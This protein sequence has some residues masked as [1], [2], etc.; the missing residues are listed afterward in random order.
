M[1]NLLDR[2]FALALPPGLSASSP[3]AREQMR[4]SRFT[5]GSLLLMICAFL[6][7]APIMILFSPHTPAAPPIAFGVLGLL[8]FTLIMSRLGRQKFAACCLIAFIFILVTGP[9]LSN[10]L[11]FSLLP[12]FSVFIV[13]TILAGVLLP[14][15][16]AIITG[17]ISCAMIAVIG[18]MSLHPGNYPRAAGR[19]SY[20]FINVISLAIMTPMIINIVIAIIVY[21]IMRSLLLTIRRA[22]QAEEIVA[23][24]SAIAAHERERMQEQRQLEE[25]LEKIAEAHARI[26]NGD[27]QARVS[28]RDG[29]VLWSIAV[30][31]N[32]LVSRLQYWKYDS[33]TLAMTRQAAAYIATQ[34]RTG[35]LT[36]QRSALP[37]TSTPL[38]PVIVEV[39]KILAETPM[40]YSRPLSS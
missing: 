3:K 21:V 18:L 31:L 19:G 24:Q 33:D 29:H 34:L 2:W 4:Y 37:L 26:A 30:P 32:N 6:P 11:D 14:P 38:D 10:Q 22:D 12:L 39:N 27:Y 16:A 9:M 5:A 25:G 13:A 28:L 1:K 40:R 35:A 15:V 23:L 7:L 36:G 8:A 17:I 20:H